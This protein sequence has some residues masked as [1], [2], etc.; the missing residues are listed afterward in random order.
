VK[1][2]TGEFL[3]ILDFANLVHLV[4]DSI[5][6]RF[7]FLVRLLLKERPLAFQPALVP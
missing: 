1:K 2:V 7:N 4:D 3:E 6:D 5:Q